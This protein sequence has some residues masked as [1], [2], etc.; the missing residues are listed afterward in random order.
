MAAQN[1][2]NRN[3]R[4]IYNMP[5]PST[6]INVKKNID[7]NFSKLIVGDELTSFFVGIEIFLFHAKYNKYCGN[8]KKP[9]NRGFFA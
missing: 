1:I 3:G 7:R 4:K 9:L 6:M 8:N 2:G 5:M